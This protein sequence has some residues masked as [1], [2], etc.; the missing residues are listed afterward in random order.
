MSLFLVRL[1]WTPFFFLF[2][3]FNRFLLFFF[4]NR[5]KN[6]FFSASF[7][8][9]VSL[10]FS[11]PLSMKIEVSHPPSCEQSGWT[12]EPNFDTWQR[13]LRTNFIAFWKHR[14]YYFFHNNLEHQ[15]TKKRTV[16]PEQQ[17][18][19]WP[20]WLSKLANQKIKRFKIRSRKKTSSSVLIFKSFSENKKKSNKF[21][22]FVVLSFLVAK[23]GNF[24]QG[25]WKN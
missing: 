8:K 19:N 9:V 20:N 16:C 1:F 14:A 11:S 23:N 13:Y 24:S 15:V 21:F 17:K 4:F 3:I 5:Q 10:S 22:H 25:I 12:K 2:F 18:I 6:G 7:Y